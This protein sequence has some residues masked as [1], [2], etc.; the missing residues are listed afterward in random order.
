MKWL[1]QNELQSDE[2]KSHLP[3]PRPYILTTTAASS[4]NIIATN[5]VATITAKNSKTERNRKRHLA[6]ISQDGFKKQKQSHKKP[7]QIKKT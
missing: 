7:N 6:P 4:L 2:K 3:L 5:K 1:E